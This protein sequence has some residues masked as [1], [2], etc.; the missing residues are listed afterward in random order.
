M[1]FN[2]SIGDKPAAE[3]DWL[4]LVWIP[5]VLYIV[6]Q[7]VSAYFTVRERYQKR[8]LLIGAVIDEIERSRDSIQVQLFA[9]RTSINNGTYRQKFDM[10]GYVFYAVESD[11]LA[12]AFDTKSGDFLF[13]SRRAYGQV[14]E[15]YDQRALVAKSLTTLGSDAFKN[16]SPDRKMATIERLTMDMDTA[17]RHAVAALTSLTGELQQREKSWKKLF[18]VL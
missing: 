10:P 12:S 14:I 5:I 6:Q 17:K 3:H 4:Q 8:T 2:L 15:F 9:F 16:L 13:L 7:L 1:S 18:L 11:D